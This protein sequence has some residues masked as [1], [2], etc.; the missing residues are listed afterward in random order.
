MNL[1]PGIIPGCPTI[2]RNVSFTFQLFHAGVH[3]L[4]KG[5]VF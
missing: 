4:I 5:V 3:L 2:C 1:L